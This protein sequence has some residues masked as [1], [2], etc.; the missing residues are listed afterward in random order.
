MRA[1]AAD[2][3]GRSWFALAWWMV[4]VL[5]MGA[6]V[7]ETC[8][9]CHNE[10]LSGGPIAGGDPNWPP[11]S[12]LTPGEDGVL[13]RY[14]TAEALT[15]MFRSGTRPDGSDIEAMPF[16]SLKEF[17]DQDMAALYTFL[18]TLTPRKTGEQG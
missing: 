6:Y 7:A 18:K 8:T 2:L 16:E 9:G 14:P 11:A 4:G 12:N 3:L 10:S 17:S 13:T 15:T 1:L 5:A